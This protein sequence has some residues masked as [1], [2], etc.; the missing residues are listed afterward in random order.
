MQQNTMQASTESNQ[1]IIKVDIIGG[2]QDADKTEFVKRFQEYMIAGSEKA[3]IP[4]LEKKGCLCCTNPDQ[5]VQSI[6]D[7]RT[8]ERPDR[9]LLEI[10]GTVKLTDIRSV[11]AQKELA[12]YF[13]IE[14]ELFLL[15]ITEYEKRKL[16]SERFLTEQLTDAILICVKRQSEL[17]KKQRTQIYQDIKQCNPQVTLKDKDWRTYSGTEFEK[18]WKENANKFQKLERK[19]HAVFRKIPINQLTS[20]ANEQTD[21][22]LQIYEEFNDW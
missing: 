3:V 18:I 6:Q 19:I 5:F 4:K 12:Q 9:I 15:D 20:K 14:H 13:T 8:K 11:F 7:I 2:F 22:N 1:T 10:G 17:D 21:L 16:I